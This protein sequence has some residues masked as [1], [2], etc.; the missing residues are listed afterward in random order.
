MDEKNR[1]EIFQKERKEPWKPKEMTFQQ[2]QEGWKAEE[3]PEQDK[4]K[5]PLPPLARQYLKDPAE[6]KPSSSNLPAEHSNPPAEHSNPPSLQPPAHSLS[7]PQSAIPSAV[8]S[9]SPLVVHD[10]N[11]FFREWAAKVDKLAFYPEFLLRMKD[12]RQL[13]QQKF[14]ERHGQ[15]TER[16]PNPQRLELE[17]KKTLVACFPA[18]SED[19]FPMVLE[20]WTFMR[21]VFLL[22][23]QSPW[24]LLMKNPDL[25]K[26]VYTAKFDRLFF[27]TIFSPIILT[28]GA[29][30]YSELFEIFKHDRTLLNKAIPYLEKREDGEVYKMLE[31]LFT[32]NHPEFLREEAL[33]LFTQL[34]PT[35]STAHQELGIKVLLCYMM[36]L[37]SFSRMMS[38]GPVLAFL[39]SIKQNNPRFIFFFT[40]LITIA[41]NHFIPDGSNNLLESIGRLFERALDYAYILIKDQH[42]N[43]HTKQ[44]F[45]GLILALLN[46]KVP[47]VADKISAHYIV[48]ASDSQTPVITEDIKKKIKEHLS[49]LIPN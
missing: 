45:P 11:R 14:P 25:S 24:G 41:D 35:Q 9:P 43:E 48:T 29:S 42:H 18:S 36:D 15:R 19:P 40:S 27:Q 47:F 30:S 4:E 49:P 7:N 38:S 33:Q 12:Q 31:R 1:K 21:I 3:K 20:S 2:Y 16:A 22:P 26:R 6:E 28:I 32:A 8:P 34:S 13:S 46:T 23:P 39:D 17:E 37:T 10:K 44:L 5:N